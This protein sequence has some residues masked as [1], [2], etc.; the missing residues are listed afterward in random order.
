MNS[1]QSGYYLLKV[2]VQLQGPASGVPRRVSVGSD[3]DEGHGS[4]GLSNAG[5]QFIHTV[6]H[7][8]QDF[9]LLS[10]WMELWEPGV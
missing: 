2:Y 8:T 4:A 6:V 1:S 9:G 3:L 5:A 7:S 10:L